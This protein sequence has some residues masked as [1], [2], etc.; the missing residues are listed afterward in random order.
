VEGR[1]LLRYIIIVRGNVD[2]IKV[3]QSKARWRAVVNTLM[4]QQV[5]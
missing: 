1:M 3:A 5:S 2:W 4:P